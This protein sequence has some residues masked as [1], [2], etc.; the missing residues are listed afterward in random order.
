MTVS[1]RTHPVQPKKIAYCGYDFFHACL[2]DLLERSFEIGCVFSFECDNRYNYN[3]YL[4]EICRNRGIPLY[5]TPVD[6][7]CVQDLARQGYELLISAGYKHKLPDLAPFGIKGIN[8]HPTLLPL[9]RGVWPLPWTLLSQQPRSGVTVHKLS[10]VFDGGDILAQRDFAVSPAEDLE[11]LSAKLQM[12]AVE[13][14]AAVVANLQ[15]SWDNATPQ[16]HRVSAVPMYSQQQRTLDWRN[17]V[18]DI[19]R[20]CRAFGKFG[21]YARFEGQDW[22]VTKLSVWSQAHGFTPGTVVHKTNTEMIV[23]AGD[24]MVCLQYFQPL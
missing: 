3:E 22:L 7:S 15:D 8:V 23:A 6:A 13:V 24:G 5:L 20:I 9:G 18:A 2:R 12:L 10:P 1:Q 11:T 21:S 17:R 16:T 4:R 19:E 14:L